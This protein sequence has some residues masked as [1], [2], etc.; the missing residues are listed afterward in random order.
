MAAVLFGVGMFCVGTLIYF[1][2]SPSPA[3]W[4]PTLSV[5]QTVMATFFLW[6]FVFTPPAKS[7]A[8][9]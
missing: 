6:R 2:I 5:L 9:A 4:N 7:F 8:K 3:Q 1:L